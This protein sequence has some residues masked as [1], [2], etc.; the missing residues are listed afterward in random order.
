MAIAHNPDLIRNSGVEEQYN[1]SGTIVSARYDRV[2]FVYGLSGVAPENVQPDA[3]Q[4]M[5]TQIPVGTPHPD[6]SIALSRYYRVQPLP[7]HD[8]VEV[9]VSYIYEQAQNANPTTYTVE[10]DG[11][12]T[13]LETDVEYTD[14]SYTTKAPIS[15]RY[16]RNWSLSV[17][18]TSG[19]PTIPTKPSGAA[20]TPL[21]A[22]GKGI[23][24]QPTGGVTITKTIN[25]T[26][27]DLLEAAMDTYLGCTNLSVW[28]AKAAGTWLCDSIR[29][30][31]N[32][33]QGVYMANIHF[34][35]FKD[36]VDPYVEYFDSVL[37]TPPNIWR[38][39]NDPTP[40]AQGTSNGKKRTRS[41]KP[42][43]FDTLLAIL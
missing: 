7:S 29:T 16:W 23:M 12:V 35:W 22:K 21:V 20:N 10:V 17:N 33:F 40:F 27:A 11:G 9:V 24:Y 26:K 36:G 15:V 30:I 5:Q 4:Y 13:S 42:V 43:N 14:N 38:D 37:G 3:I 25:S 32:P 1:A 31:S 39:P 18:A 6:R 41:V 28:R 8:A 2:F 34:T 19:L